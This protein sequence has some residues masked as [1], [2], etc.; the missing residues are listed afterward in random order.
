MISVDMLLTLY[1]LGVFIM[2]VIPMVPVIQAVW[3]KNEY[4]PLPVNLAYTKDPRAIVKYF[5]QYFYESFGDTTLNPGKILKS[6]RL[7]KLE[8]IE[9]P[10]KKKVYKEMVYIVG[11]TTIPE[12]VKFEKGVVSDEELIF[13]EGCYSRVI[14]TTN[15]VTLGEKN[16]ITRWID[17]E[18]ILVVGSNSH[19]N[20]ASSLSVIHL[21]TGVSF[22]RL[23]GY[24]I[25]TSHTFSFNKNLQAVRKE[26]LDEAKIDE[27]LLYIFDKQYRINA[28][29]T[30]FRSIVT[31][32]DLILET[33]VKLFGNVKANGD[34]IL[35]EN[36][37][38]D[39]N[40]IAE[41]SIKIGKNCFVSGDL[42]SRNTITIDSY[43]QIGTQEHSK[44]VVAK[45]RISLS[46]H[47]AIFNYLLTDEVGE[48]I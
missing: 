23:Y 25:L 26:H 37:F 19:I 29:D 12:G 20:I 47:V 9:A 28:A 1:I 18:G 40:I 39:G 35:K 6:Q 3:D 8:V 13:G 5:N 44:S 2:M 33:G 11:K 24:P 34:V 15:K 21:T 43:T 36:C 32:G 46:E 48:V 31:Q 45:K 42:F 27:N 41:G 38:V 7:G 10:L 17:S 22:H 30:R 16:C 14:R 4:S